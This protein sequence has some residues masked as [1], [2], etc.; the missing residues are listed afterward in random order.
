[1]PHPWLPPRL[2]PLRHPATAALPGGL[3]IRRIPLPKSQ[4][5]AI[6]AEMPTV[7]YDFDQIRTGPGPRV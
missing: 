6:I 4:T 3:T 1:M 2:L 5:L 7:V